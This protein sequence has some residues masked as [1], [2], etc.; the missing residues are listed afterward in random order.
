VTLPLISRA[1]ALGAMVLCCSALLVG[2][3]GS[4]TGNSHA[5]A[6]PAKTPATDT[7]QAFGTVPQA[8]VSIKEIGL[9]PKGYVTL[10]NFTDERQR[11]LRL[12]LCQGANC[13]DL[14]DVSV[15]AGSPARVATGPGKGLGGVVM[16]DAALGDLKASN[17]EL[18]IFAK[19]PAGSRRLV[20]FMEWG[21]TP[22][23]HT[24]EAIASGLWIKGA[25]APTAPTAVRLHQKPGGLWVFDTR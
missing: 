12:S 4:R 11:L 2:C 20:T 3:G 24:R 10:F 5:Q 13:V 21:S 9:G 25:Y 7:P 23:M 16:A 15:K 17:G 6:Q 8:L 19:D 22:H 14:P 1:T 18:A